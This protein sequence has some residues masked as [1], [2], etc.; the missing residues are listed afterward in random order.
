MPGR[1]R[2]TDYDKLMKPLGDGAGLPDGLPAV[3]LHQDGCG[4]D[5][6]GSYDCDFL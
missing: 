2:P 6:G 4:R 5:R 3:A 1:D